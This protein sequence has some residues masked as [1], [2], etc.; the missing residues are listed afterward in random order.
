V[1]KPRDDECLEVNFND[2]RAYV[3]NS[4]NDSKKRG[5]NNC[6]APEITKGPKEAFYFKYYRFLSVIR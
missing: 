1:V 5:E 3:I 2:Y 4:G 6:N